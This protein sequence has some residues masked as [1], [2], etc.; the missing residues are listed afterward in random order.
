MQVRAC[1]LVHF[2]KFSCHLVKA[3]VASE[4]PPYG[5]INTRHRP[6]KLGL[7]LRHD[8]CFGTWRRPHVADNS[9][10]LSWNRGDALVWGSNKVYISNHTKY[11][12]IRW[13]RENTWNLSGALKP[14]YDSKLPICNSKWFKIKAT[15][16]RNAFSTVDR[17]PLIPVDLRDA[18]V[19]DVMCIGGPANFVRRSQLETSPASFVSVCSHSSTEHLG[20]LLWQFYRKNWAASNE[21]P[22]IKLRFAMHCSNSGQ[23]RAFGQSAVAIAFNPLTPKSDQVQISPVA[24]PVILH[25]TVWRT[26][27]F[28]AYS[29]WKMIIVPVLTTSLIH[30]SWKGWEN[31]L[32]ELGIERVKVKLRGWLV[33]AIF[34]GW[35]PCYCG[36]V[37][38]WHI[39]RR[40]PL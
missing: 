20:A 4:K 26:W 13:R 19:L 29:D 38:S 27:L 17:A 18:N 7:R 40:K 25:H 39:A 22:W 5:Q 33:F 11:I 16:L 28:I 34:G 8:I 24:S 6:S 31:V 2:H 1:C 21:W 14:Q 10:L 9:T 36:L 3:L 15:I 35:S 12:L 32:F 23:T 37:S 30:F